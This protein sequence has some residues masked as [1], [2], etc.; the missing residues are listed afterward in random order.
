METGAGGSKQI[1]S[2]CEGV[3]WVV[4]FVGGGEA[5]EGSCLTV[6]RGDGL[7]SRRFHISRHS[8]A[9]HGLRRFVPYDILFLARAGNG[10]SG[11][12]L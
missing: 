5:E 6:G 1:E 10:G 9:P 4:H 7:S 3:A 11:S 2:L 12:S 8:L